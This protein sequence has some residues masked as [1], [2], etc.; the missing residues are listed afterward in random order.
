[1]YGLTGM[2]SAPS[3]S[4]IPPT[5]DVVANSTDSTGTRVGDAVTRIAA[6]AGVQTIDSTSSAPTTWIDIATVRPS[7]SMNTGDSNRTGTPRAA[8]A[9]G[10]VLANINGRHITASATTTSTDVQIR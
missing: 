10:S 3:E 6:A 9:S 8:A 1:M 2:L 5:V 7:T 4:R